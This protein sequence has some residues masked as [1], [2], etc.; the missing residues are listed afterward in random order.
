M[1]VTCSA[2]NILQRHV[3]VTELRRFPHFK[4]ML[5]SR[6][7]LV[8]TGSTRAQTQKKDLPQIEQV[9]KI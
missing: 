2:Q 3:P 7:R 6:A 8:T 9:P 4:P 5:Q 1:N